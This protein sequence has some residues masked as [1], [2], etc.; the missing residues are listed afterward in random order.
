MPH[1][2]PNWP[3]AGAWIRGE[4]AG[5][6]AVG[7]LA[8]LGAPLSRASITPGRCD[9]APAAVRE[10]FERFSPYDVAEA[11]DV[12]DLAVRDLGDL[13]VASLSPEEA[14]EPIR[15]GVARALADADAVIVLGGDN[16]ITRPAC[17]ALGDECSLITF[18]AH[19]DLRDVDRGLTNGNPV[20]ALLRDGLPGSR[21]V[22]VGIQSFA[23]SRAYAAVAA[24]AGITVIS[25]DDVH[26]N[27]IDAAVRRALDL[28]PHGR[29][30]ADFDL[31][32]LDRCFA[33]AAPGSRPGG[34]APW[35]LMRA[36]RMCG[37]DARVAAIDVV[38]IDPNKDSSS[39][40]ALAAASCILAF[41]SGVHR[42]CS[43]SR[44]VRN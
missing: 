28:L 34:L 22:Q 5:A 41:A 18:D 8:M 15:S 25:A 17:R 29:I 26:L 27:G 19:F 12:A 2:D 30:Y 21:I 38:E 9:L 43:R 4:L 24:Q 37:A 31:D 6:G 36:A 39:R 42:R 11:C 33:P 23:N 14:F 44:D 35:Q 20:R 13:D 7:R 1:P 40:T 10:A 3:R 32:V 16:S